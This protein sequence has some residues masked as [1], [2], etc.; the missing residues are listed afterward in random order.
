MINKE[1]RD[2]LRAAYIEWYC[3][4]VSSGREEHERSAGRNFDEFCPPPKLPLPPCPGCGWK[5][6]ADVLHTGSTV[7]SL[8]CN[9]GSADCGWRGPWAATEAE[10]IER[11]TLP[12]DLRAAEARLEEC[13]EWTHGY[14]DTQAELRAESLR[15]ELARL[16]ARAK[17]LR[18]QTPEERGRG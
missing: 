16:Q 14:T 17:E 11:A 18:G 9:R 10:A 8:R 5:T 15:A 2:Q 7:R 4:R 13:E 6:M 1:D 12:G 3:Q